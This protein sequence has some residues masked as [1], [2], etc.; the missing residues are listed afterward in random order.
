MQRKE[1]R[2]SKQYE[3][4]PNEEAFL[5]RLNNILEPNQEEEYEELTEDYPTLFIIGAPKSGTTLL[6]QLISANM[7]IGYINKLTASFWKAPVYGVKLTQKLL[8]SFNESSFQSQF[9]RTPGINEPH[10]FGYFWA[11]F[12]GENHLS[13]KLK[14]FEKKVNWDQ[15]RKIIV[16]I[17][18]TFKKPVIYKYLPI[19]WYIEPIKKT[20]KKACFIKISRDPVQNAISIFN[21]RKKFLDSQQQWFSLKPLEYEEL[22]NMPFYKQ[23]AG[24]VFYIEQ[25]LINELK[26]INKNSVLYLDY[27]DLCKNPAQ[28]LTQ[29]KNMLA[30]KGH[31]SDITVKSIN[32]FKEKILNPNSM[33]EY[34]KIAKAVSQ[35]YENASGDIKGIKSKK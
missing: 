9:G 12:F 17:A 29:V 13:Q 15:I 19:G 8:P 31:K 27:H 5:Q 14:E 32:S 18:F 20:L 25:F 35:F 34:S 2:V 4:K 11:T 1:H 22:K 26:K 33:E 24:Q 7:D 3:K 16:N 6:S 28:V 21:T 10:E 30:I 23:T